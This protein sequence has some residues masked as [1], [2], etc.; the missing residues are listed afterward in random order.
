MKVGDLIKT[1]YGFAHVMKFYAP[2]YVGAIVLEGKYLGMWV[3]LR[4]YDLNQA[5]KW[6]NESR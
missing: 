5:Q 1:Y 3:H 2:E 4:G 6:L